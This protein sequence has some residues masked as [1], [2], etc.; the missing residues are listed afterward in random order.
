MLLNREGAGAAMDPAKTLEMKDHLEKA[1]ALDP[2]YAD[3]YHLLAFARISIEDKKGAV[4]AARRA[5][6]LNPRNPDYRMNLAQMYA[7]SQQWEGALAVLKTLEKSDV[8]EVVDRAEDFQARVEA[9]REYA[10]RGVR[11]EGYSQGT[12]TNSPPVGLPPAE[13]DAPPVQSSTTS[14]A[15]RF[16]RGKLIKVDCSAKP[17]AVLTVTNALKT[18]KLKV[19]DTGQIV[20]IGAKS[21]GCDWTN[22]EVAVNFRETGAGEGTVVSLEV[23]E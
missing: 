3:A 15:V 4:E 22:K 12:Q 14:R 18:W 10:Q 21:L 8:P 23:Q 17:E 19:A 7:L 9:M 11:V 16:T 20:L 5:V 6:E 1:I 2:E 13:A